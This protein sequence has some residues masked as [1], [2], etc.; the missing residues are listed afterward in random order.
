MATKRRRCSAARTCRS[1]TYLEH[2]GEARAQRQRDRPVP[3]GGAD[4]RRRTPMRHGRGSSRRPSV[5]RRVGTRW[6]RT[7]ASTARG[8]EVLR[9]WLRL[10]NDDVNEEWL[11]DKARYQVEGLTSRRLDKVWIRR[12]S[13]S[14]WGQA[15]AGHVGRGLRGNRQAASSQPGARG[16][17]RS[18]ATCSTARRCSPR[19]SCPPRSARACD[20]E[21]LRRGR[22]SRL[23]GRQPRRGRLQPLDFRRD[24][25]RRRGPDRRQPRPRWEAP[26]VN[27]RLRKAAKRGRAK[28]FIPFGLLGTGI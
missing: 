16:S 1:R 14:G 23:S 10:N 27:V 20:R 4:Q 11:S 28:A 15:R 12:P 6:A 25:G 22:G 7:S 9:P 24:R 18:P 13:K 3:G 26:L 2:A 8:R 19:R 17:P 5:D 21:P